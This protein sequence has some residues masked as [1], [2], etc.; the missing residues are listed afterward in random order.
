MQRLGTLL[1]LLLLL[2]ATASSEVIPKG[3][4]QPRGPHQAA[5]QKQRIA[6]LSE[7]QRIALARAFYN[8]NWNRMSK[9]YG[10]QGQP[11]PLVNFLPTAY[12]DRSAQ[13]GAG[14][15][16][17]REV[18][19]GRDA[20]KTLL[21]NH[22]PMK[23]AGQTLLAHEWF[24]NFQQPEL[25]SQSRD[26]P[27]N[28]QPI[29]QGAINF[30]ENVVSRLHRRNAMAKLQQKGDKDRLRILKRR[31]PAPLDVSQLGS[32]YGANPTGIL[33]PGYSP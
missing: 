4:W 5:A 28:D 22:G 18:D 25:Y 24:H 30:S 33:Y 31:T 20:L 9:F 7:D 6:S 10:A 17:M 27:H 8:R 19:I 12:G 3:Q 13:V 15:G 14:P 32:N 11:P 2:P 21:F 1:V 26:L 16:G 29:E 23:R